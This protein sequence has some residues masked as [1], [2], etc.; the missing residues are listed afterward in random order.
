MT[1]P[2]G[3]VIFSPVMNKRFL[4]FSIFL[5]AMVFLLPGLLFFSCNKSIEEPKHKNSGRN[6]VYLKIDDSEHLIHE[7]LHFNKNAR[8]SIWGYEETD[9]KPRVEIVEA[10]GRETFDLIVNF[11]SKDGKP[12]GLSNVEVDMLRSGDG[13]VLERLSLNMNVYSAKHDKVVVIYDFQITPKSMQIERLDEKK[14][15]IALSFMVDYID[16]SNKSLSGTLYF[17]MDCDYATI[18]RKK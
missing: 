17:Y 7:G 5:R 15:Q 2:K 10:N 4:N 11:K 13:L 3:S 12:V 8:G 18:R 1:G 16:L 9:Y 14:Q 6:F